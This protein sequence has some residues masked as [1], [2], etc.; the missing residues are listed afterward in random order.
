MMKR[1]LKYRVREALYI[2]VET[3]V[4]LLALI[5]IVAVIALIG[6]VGYAGLKAFAGMMGVC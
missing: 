3:G 4:F 5:V 2:S 6:I 1:E